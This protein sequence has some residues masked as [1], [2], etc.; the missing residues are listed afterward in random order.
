MSLSEN[1]ISVGATGKI[2]EKILWWIWPA[3][4]GKK[5]Q[6]YFHY[7]PSLHIS[8]ML[9][10]TQLL[11]FTLMVFIVIV[12]GTWFHAMPIINNGVRIILIMLISILTAR[13]PAIND[14]RQTCSLT[15]TRIILWSSQQS[16][17]YDR[18]QTFFYELLNVLGYFRLLVDNKLLVR[19]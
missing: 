6:P 4:I 7:W 13:N 1:A 19:R 9:Q 18:N 16:Q 2:Y 17:Y 15:A 14:Y 11:E 3:R 8:T 10:K 5:Y 12:Y